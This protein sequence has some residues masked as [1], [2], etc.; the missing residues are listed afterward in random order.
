M[1]FFLFSQKINQIYISIK[2]NR[3][4]D[5]QSEELDFLSVKLV[6]TTCGV[7]ENLRLGEEER[8]KKKEKKPRLFLYAPVNSYDPPGEAEDE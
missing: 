5:I 2:N 1:Y 8:V 4:L 6:L 7:V 3:D